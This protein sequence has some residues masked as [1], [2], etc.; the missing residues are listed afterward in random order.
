MLREPDRSCVIFS[1]KSDSHPNS[2]VKS[3]TQHLLANISIALPTALVLED[4]LCTFRFGTIGPAGANS[5]HIPQLKH[6]FLLSWIVY[7]LQIISIERKIPSLQ[8][9]E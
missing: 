3:T 9:P 6:L 4:F 2:T 8:E 1:M 7:T 5:T